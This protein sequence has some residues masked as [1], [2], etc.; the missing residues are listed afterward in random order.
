MPQIL[1]G[2][3]GWTYPSWKGMFYPKDLPGN[4]FLEFYTTR[5]PTTEINSS[6]Y[7]LPKPSTYEKWAAKAPGGFIFSVKVSRLITHS[8]RLEGVDEMW[9]MFLKSTHALGTHLGPILFQFPATF[10]R[11]HARLNE[12]L[13]MVRMDTLGIDRLRLVFEFRH[14][15]WFSNNVYRLLSRHGAA[16][17][18]ADSAEYPRRDVITADFVYVR[19]HGRTRLFTSN[20]VRTELA[21]EAKKFSRFMR[22]GY[23]V[24]IYFNNDAEG[25][26]VANALT[27]TT[28]MRGHRNK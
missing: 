1:V 21:N 14:E 28:M 22:E 16:L 8:K 17:C 25:H 20:Y 6:F 15:S 19:F 10:P 24:Y 27:L 11:N 26:A 7:R 12:F 3:S 23:D 18:I 4:R 9:H 13:K 2:T 5:F